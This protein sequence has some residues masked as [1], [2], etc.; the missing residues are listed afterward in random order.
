IPPF[1]EVI[2]MTA[3]FVCGSELAEGARACPVCGTSVES[4]PA[5]ALP[6]P[7]PAPTPAPVQAS[8]VQAG[9]AAMPA[10]SGPRICPVCRERYDDDYDDSFCACGT[11]LVADTSAREEPDID[12]EPARATP[13][14]PLEE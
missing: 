8:L 3:C 12:L 14:V 2:P 5:P 13:D 1:A 9:P 7:E 4:A 10:A 6:A 11:A